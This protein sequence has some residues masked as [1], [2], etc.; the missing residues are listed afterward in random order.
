MHP[1]S[2]MSSF[3]RQV[4]THLP[5]S[6]AHT[7]ATLPATAFPLLAH[8]PPRCPVYAFYVRP[9]GDSVRVLGTTDHKFAITHESLDP[10]PDHT[11]H[12]FGCLE[13]AMDIFRTLLLRD[14]PIRWIR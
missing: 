8:Q 1:T 12:V 4:A 14:Y 6:K 9:G 11:H 2:T 7:T 13:D 3:D 5:D 10:D